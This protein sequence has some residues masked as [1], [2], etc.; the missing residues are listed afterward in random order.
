MTDQTP[1]L[2]EF[3][4]ARI[5]ED[6]AVALAASPGPW[7]VD[8]NNPEGV[9]AVDDIQVVDAFALSGPQTRATATHIALYDPAR[10]LAECE[11]MRRIVELHGG[12]YDGECSSPSHLDGPC[13]TLRALATPHADHPD[14]QPEW[15]P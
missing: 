9:L 2:T 15:K 5:A 14:Y 1:T 11:A 7:R 3:L 12:D 8:P 4:L 10:V 6:E 13:R